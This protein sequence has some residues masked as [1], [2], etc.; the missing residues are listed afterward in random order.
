MPDEPYDPCPSGAPGVIDLGHDVR[1]RFASRADYAAAE[2][3]QLGPDESADVPLARSG[4]IESHPRADGGRCSGHVTFDVPVNAA[5][6]RPKWRVLSE[7]PLTLEPSLLCR[8]C[9]HH[10]FIRDGRWVPA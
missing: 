7:D 6:T 1:I 2:Q 3:L 4:L 8:A 9:G 5:E 10:G